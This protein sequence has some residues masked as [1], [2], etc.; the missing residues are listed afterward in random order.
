MSGAIYGGE[1]TGAVVFEVGAYE[2]KAGIAGEDLPSCMFSSSSGYLPAAAVDGMDT[3]VA[4][5]AK[6]TKK[7]SPYYIGHQNNVY[8]EDMTIKCP[9]EDGVIVDWDL[10]E[11]HL[12]YAM[13]ELSCNPEE[14]PILVGDEAWSSRE[15]REKLTE[16]M[17]ETYKT[18]A[19]FLGKKPV[20]SAFANGKSNALVFD[21]GLSGG[22]VVPVYEGYAIQ[23]AITRTN[24][25]ASLLLNVYQS[26]LES[27]NI[28]VVPKFMISKR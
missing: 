4:D 13:S 26:Y 23:K 8:R 16:I 22:S 21:M 27:Q 6:P 15:Q 14:H 17:F 2:T 11:A 9:V 12:H 24:L 1:E 20:L 19:Y 7:R 10:Y 28:T 18:P 5:D 3:D 25:S